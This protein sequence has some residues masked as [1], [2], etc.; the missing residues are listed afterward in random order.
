MVTD[1]DRQSLTLYPELRRL[2]ELREGY[3]WVFEVERDGI[4]EI[5]LVVG[6]R[7]WPSGWSEAVAI[8]DLHDVCGCRLDPAHGEVWMR[9]GGL[10]E[11][12]DE[13]VTLPAPGQPGTPRLVRGRPLPRELW[14]PPT[15]RGLR[16]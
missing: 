4:G 6:G 10:V 1:G 8:R 15:A 5:Q 7:L 3:R 16:P 2:L 9:E 14:L 11:V 12:I 13:L